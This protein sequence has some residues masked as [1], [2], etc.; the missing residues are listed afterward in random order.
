MATQNGGY[1]VFLFGCLAKAS[2]IPFGLQGKP[3]AIVHVAP[4]AIFI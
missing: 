4:F 1:G 3:L 2:G